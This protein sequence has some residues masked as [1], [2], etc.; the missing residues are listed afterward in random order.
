MDDFDFEQEFSEW[1]FIR[2][3]A[4]ASQNGIATSASI[5][6]SYITSPQ[7][8]ITPK[9]ISSSSNVNG[10]IIFSL[11]EHVILSVLH[12]SCTD[13]YSL[14]RYVSWLHFFSVPLR[15]SYPSSILHFAHVFHCDIGN[16]SS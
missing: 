16:A 13:A 4:T 1:V 8:T 10:D 3:Y 5:S 6:S 14:Y 11:P 2:E 7:H 9:D 15:L 12:Y